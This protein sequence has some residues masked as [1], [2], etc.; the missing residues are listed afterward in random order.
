M[1]VVSTFCSKKEVSDF[2]N[3]LLVSVIFNFKSN[4]VLA[5]SESG[6]NTSLVLSTLIK[7][8]IFAFLKST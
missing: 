2:F 7:S 1:A 4:A 5:A 8:G 6:F 3:R